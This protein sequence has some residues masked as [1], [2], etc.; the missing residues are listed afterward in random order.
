MVC[1]RLTAE[2]AAVVAA[3]LSGPRIGRYVLSRLTASDSRADRP[4][5]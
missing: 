3:A 4:E 5:R 2:A 1:F